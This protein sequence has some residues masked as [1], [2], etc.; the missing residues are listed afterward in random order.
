MIKNF[1]SIQM[2]YGIIACLYFLVF[3]VTLDM[4]YFVLGL[5][6]FVLN[7]TSEI[8]EEIKELKNKIQ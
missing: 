6:F 5:L 7:N 8:L 3:V 2:F 1:L 4:F